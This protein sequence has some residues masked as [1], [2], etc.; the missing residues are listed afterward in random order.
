M[1]NTKLTTTSYA[2]LGQLALRPWSMYELA[3]EMRRN[4]RYFYPRA[5]SRLYEEP[6]RL[7]ALGLAQADKVATGRRNRTIYAITKAGEKELRRWLADPASKGISLEFEGLLRVFLAPFGRTEDLT[8]ALKQARSDIADVIEMAARIRG[9][10]LAEQAPFQ[11]YAT[12]RV[13][14][15]DFLFHFATMVEDWAERSLAEV[16]RWESMSE[17]ERRVRA[18][19]KFRANTRRG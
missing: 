12:T 17:E 11:R 1:A 4:L 16:A 10:Y 19:R 9:E 3:A 18:L 14:V 13:M 5:E 8:A 15:H 2:I 7:V 6:K